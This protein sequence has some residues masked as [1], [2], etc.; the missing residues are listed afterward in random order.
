MVLAVIM[1]VSYIASNLHSTLS[2][3]IGDRGDE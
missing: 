2:T 3:L 1:D